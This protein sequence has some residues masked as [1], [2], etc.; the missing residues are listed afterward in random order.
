[1]VKYGKNDIIIIIICGLFKNKLNY[2]FSYIKELLWKLKSVIIIHKMMKTN[3]MNTLKIL[4]KQQH[5]L[6]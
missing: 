6:Q 5:W 1:M 3:V 2:L 4:Y